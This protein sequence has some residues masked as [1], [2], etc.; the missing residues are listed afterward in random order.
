LPVRASLPLRPAASAGPP[1]IT[2]ATTT[3]LRPVQG[4][5][6]TGLP[7]SLTVMPIHGLGRSICSA[8]S[9]FSADMAL[10]KKERNKT[11]GRTALALLILHPL[12]AGLRE[13]R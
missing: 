2:S 9:I 13:G 10:R 11:K 3:P 5:P 8:A 1:L 7:A 12:V 6:G 4:S